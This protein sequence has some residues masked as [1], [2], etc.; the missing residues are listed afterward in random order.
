MR[1]NDLFIKTWGGRE[2]KNPNEGHP[3]WATSD[4]FVQPQLYILTNWKT[5]YGVD[6][7]ANSKAAL[8]YKLNS[9]P[10]GSRDPL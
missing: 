5:Q 9:G 10:A 2:A 7:E 8:E 4:G 3:S 6:S 1:E